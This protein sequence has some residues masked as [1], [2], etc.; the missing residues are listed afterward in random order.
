[1]INYIYSYIFKLKFLKTISYFS[2]QSLY[3]KTNTY[4]KVKYY[5]FDTKEYFMLIKGRN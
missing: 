4:Q 5:D 2:V 1:M 3:F